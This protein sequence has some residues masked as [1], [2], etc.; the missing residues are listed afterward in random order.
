MTAVAD[1]TLAALLE[2]LLPDIE[3]TAY[4]PATRKLALYSRKFDERQVT[5]L[6]K[7]LIDL[8][9]MLEASGPKRSA[10]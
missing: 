4:E 5:T 10:L 2:E 6:G 1:I 9:E 7:L 3:V 8:G